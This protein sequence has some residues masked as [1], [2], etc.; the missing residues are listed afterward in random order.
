MIIDLKR[1]AYMD[2][3]TRGVLQIGNSTFQTVE[4]PWVP[5]LEG[6]GGTPFESCIP[7]GD[8]HLRHF[9]RPTGQKSL[10]LSNPEHG[11]YEE[12]EDRLAGEGRYLILIHPGNTVADVVGCIAPGLHGDETGVGSS[13]LAMK[14]ILELLEGFEHTIRISPKGAA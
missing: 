10:I 14:K 9:T 2:D 3:R 6:P 4:R 8:Y 12:D 11:V 1:F 13:R 5:F 7:D